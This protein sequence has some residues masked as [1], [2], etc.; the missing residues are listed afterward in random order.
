[1]IGKFLIKFTQFEKT[2]SIIKFFLILLKNLQKNPLSKL[3]VR[4]V[5]RDIY[6]FAVR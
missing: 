1:M 2:G 4:R 3:E 6:T 5:F